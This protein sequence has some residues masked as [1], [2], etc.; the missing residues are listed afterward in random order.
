MRG[1]HVFLKKIALT[2]AGFA[3]GVAMTLASVS[4]TVS[5]V[6]AQMSGDQAYMLAQKAAVAHAT[7]QLDS[8]GLHGIDEGAHAGTIPAGALGSVR[9]ARIAVQAAEWPDAL[10][11]MAMD[12][13][14]NMKALEEALR[15]E[16]PAKVADPAEKVHEGGHDLSAAVYAW[17]E[18]GKAPEM[19]S[20]HGH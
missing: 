13:V 9:R 14:M 1:L 4:A 10:K 19:G 11:D 5:P 3:A 12:Q 18:T 20:G 6:S 16:D 2:A 15:T 17:L 8:A 7:F